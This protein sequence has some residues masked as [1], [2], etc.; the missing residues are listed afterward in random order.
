MPAVLL[1][2]TPFALVQHTAN[3]ATTFVAQVSRRRPTEAHR[4][5]VWQCILL[6]LFAGSAFLGRD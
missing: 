1:Y 5:S 6:Q 3:Y 2:W 4:S